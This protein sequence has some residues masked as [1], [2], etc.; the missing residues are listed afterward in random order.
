MGERICSSVDK[1]IWARTLA[2]GGSQNKF[3]VYERDEEWRLPNGAGTHKTKAVGDDYVQ[4]MMD[5]LVGMLRFC[6]EA[7]KTHRE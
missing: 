5:W 6:F 3:Y 1:L 4:N 2:N 7:W